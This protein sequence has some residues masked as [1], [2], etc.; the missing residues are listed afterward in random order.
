M[1]DNG[2]TGGWGMRA[3]TTLHLGG[4]VGSRWAR[5]GGGGSARGGEGAAVAEGETR[6]GGQAATKQR[7]DDGGGIDGELI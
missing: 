3:A 7:T 1:G 2:S 4:A 5:C 6:E